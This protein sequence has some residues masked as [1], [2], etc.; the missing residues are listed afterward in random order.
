MLLNDEKH[1]FQRALKNYWENVFFVI[2]KH[3]SNFVMIKISPEVEEP[4][5]RNVLFLKFCLKFLNSRV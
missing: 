1:V 5:G 4:I 3:T 2:L